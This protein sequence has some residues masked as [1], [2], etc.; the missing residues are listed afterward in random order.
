MA[1]GR[2]RL[3]VGG[4][5]GGKRKW[6]AIV[7]AAG[8]VPWASVP[9]LELPP[10]RSLLSGRGSCHVRAW[11]IVTLG[12][13]TLFSRQYPTPALVC[14]VWPREIGFI[15][16]RVDFQL[17]AGWSLLSTLQIFSTAGWSSL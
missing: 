3:V 11:V 16:I 1:W 6:D 9:H 12:L 14:L 2:R 8:E 7:S 5:L 15:L 10:L 17:Q 4:C 13:A